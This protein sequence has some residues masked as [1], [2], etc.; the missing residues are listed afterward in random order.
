MPA[1]SVS[2]E[3]LPGSKMAIFLLC[4]HLGEEV[5]M[6]LG[7][8]LEGYSLEPGLCDTGGAM[9]SLDQETVT[10]RVI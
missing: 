7:Y 4:L 1:G 8:L 9:K 5:R 2:G 6:S 10:N 3:D